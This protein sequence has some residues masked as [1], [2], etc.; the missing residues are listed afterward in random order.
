MP[1]AADFTDELESGR[2]HFAFVGL[3]VCGPQDLDASAHIHT[4]TLETSPKILTLRASVTG[5]PLD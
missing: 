3:A 2:P 1:E 4:F 5:D